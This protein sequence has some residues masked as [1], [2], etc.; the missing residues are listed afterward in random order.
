MAGQR[1][2]GEGTASLEKAIDV[3]EAIGESDRGIGHLELAEKIGLPK[4]TV[5]RILS[6]LVARGMVWRDPLRR[7][8]CLGARTIE[9]ARKAYSM[10]ELVAASRAEL[11]TLR[12]VT[13]ETTYLAALDGTETVSLERCEGAHNVRSASTLG[14]RKPLYCTS[15]GK[16]M[17]AALPEEAR[18]AILAELDLVP[19]TRKTIPC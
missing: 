4:T 13:G 6:T 15:Q 3:L 17:L 9:L 11:R 5:Y 1:A 19:L 2:S 14:V 16:A 7:V 18:N 10:P 12:D 8:Y